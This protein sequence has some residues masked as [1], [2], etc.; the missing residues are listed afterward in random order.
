MNVLRPAGIYGPG[1]RLE[2]PQYQQLRRQR[3]VVELRG[4]SSS[5][6]RTSTTSSHAI[7]AILADPSPHGTVFNVGGERVLPLQELQ[8]LQAEILGIRRRRLVIPTWLAGPAAA[9][10][11]R[12]LARKRRT[13]PPLTAMARGELFSAAV[14]DRRLRQRYPELR[15]TPLRTG[16][17]ETFEWALARGL[18]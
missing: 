7:L 1:S 17:V 11:V 3:W 5:T 10:A 16:L 15:V 12:L 2:L 6:R 4:A 18:I 13:E 14:D 8:A 9:L